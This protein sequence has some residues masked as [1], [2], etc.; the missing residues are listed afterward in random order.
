[1]RTGKKRY[2]CSFI[3]KNEIGDCK[4]NVIVVSALNEIFAKVLLCNT[5]N[6]PN[7]KITPN[8]HGDYLTE[9]IKSIRVSETNTY[10]GQTETDNFSGNS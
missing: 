7:V 8:K 2:I 4:P 6:I 5:H 10:D 1:M 3:K 9:G